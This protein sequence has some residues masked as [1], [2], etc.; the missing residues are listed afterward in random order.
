MSISSL[1]SWNIHAL[2]NYF[3]CFMAGHHIPIVM[4]TPM[5]TTY[6]GDSSSMKMLTTRTANRAR[7]SPYALPSGVTT[8]S[9][10]VGQLSH[11]SSQPHPFQYWHQATSP[12]T[13]TTLNQQSHQNSTNRHAN[14]QL[15]HQ[16]SSLLTPGVSPS[17]AGSPGL[18]PGQIQPTLAY[19]VGYSTVATT[20][21]TPSY[22]TSQPTLQQS[23]TL[24]RLPSQTTFSPQE[25]TT[26]GSPQI[27]QAQQPQQHWVQTAYP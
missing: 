16:Q 15:P 7:Y 14:S 12:Y 24:E 9:N 3:F 2:V 13:P 1:P 17:L 8:T 23:P 11:L 25:S 27:S 26:Y 22:N 6:R 21:A 18:L 10:S 4:D 20:V 19:D 5:L